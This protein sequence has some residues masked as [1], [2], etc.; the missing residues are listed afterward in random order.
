MSAVVSNYVL[1]NAQPSVT[2]SAIYLQMLRSAEWCQWLPVIYHRIIDS[3]V[4][5]AAD[6]YQA[7][8]L[9]CQSQFSL[10]I[11]DEVGR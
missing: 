4:F 9:V 11:V 3:D 8:V 10:L 2:E 1:V 7:F 6:F 5:W